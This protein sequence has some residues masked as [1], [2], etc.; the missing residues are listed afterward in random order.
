MKK[1]AIGILI[2][3]SFPSVAV[4]VHPTEEFRN[5]GQCER[6]LAQARNEARQNPEEYNDQQRFVLENSR[7]VRTAEGDAFFVQTPMM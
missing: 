6:A 3:A 7:C 4:A 1:L 5:R 2:A